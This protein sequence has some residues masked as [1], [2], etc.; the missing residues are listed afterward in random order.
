M[1]VR[2][3]FVAIDISEDVRGRVAAYISRLRIDFPGVPV[4]WESPEKLHLTMRFFGN[5]DD[6][7]LEE[8]SSQVETAARFLPFTG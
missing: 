5:V 7:G 4:K 2:R 8:I 6:A 1:P 3:I